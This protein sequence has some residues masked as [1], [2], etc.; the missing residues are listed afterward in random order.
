MGTTFTNPPE[1]LGT[2]GTFPNF[3][4]QAVRASLSCRG[5]GEGFFGRPPFR[6]ASKRKVDRSSPATN[7]AAP[8]MSGGWPSLSRFLRRLGC[9]S[10]TAEG[11]FLS[12]LKHVLGT[13]TLPTSTASA[14]HHLLL[15]S[16][17]SSFPYTR[18]EKYI[19]EFSLKPLE[20]VQEA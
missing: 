10:V 4:D 7:S 18:S 19:R 14:L 3:R 8:R 16:S 5:S 13:E 2:D 1:N 20:T 9:S 15:P 17:R 12:K 11:F 6:G